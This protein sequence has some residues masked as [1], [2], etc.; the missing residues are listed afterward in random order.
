MPPRPLPRIGA[1]IL[2]GGLSTRMGRDKSKLRLGQLTLTGILRRTCQEAGL[3]V[4]VVR[5]DAVPRCGPL[6]GIV[7]GLTRTR[8]DALVFLSCDMPLVS[9][10]LIRRLVREARRCQ[11]SVFFTDEAG[12]GF[13]CLLWKSNLPLVEQQIRRSS[14]SLQALARA[15]STAQL[16]P[17]RQEQNQRL[18]VNTP[19]EWEA[20]RLRWIQK[21]R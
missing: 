9:A 20:V 17:T 11:Q 12:V 15:L 18:N 8:S 6:G 2:A 4:R 10:R 7:T 13:P 14:L 16:R 1:V 3:A 5:R 21:H 19:S